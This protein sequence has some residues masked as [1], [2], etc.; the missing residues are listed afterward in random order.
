MTLRFPAAALA[1]LLLLPL[2]A[3]SASAGSARAEAPSAYADERRDELLALAAD[4]AAQR[5]L[6]A[7]WVEQTLLHAQRLPAVLRLM[8]PA[9]AGTAKNWAAYR[10]R[11]VEPL[12]TRAGVAFWREHAHWLREAEARWGVPPEIVVGVIGVET[13]YGRQLGDFRVLDVLT[14]LSLDFPK[15]ARR[16]R[17]AFFRDELATYLLLCRSQDLDPLALR[18]SYAG[19]SGQPQFMP[20]SL[21]RYAVDFDGDG[22][23]DL[24]HSAADTIGSV[25]NYLAEFGWQRGMA[26]HHAVLEPVDARD[27]ATLLAPDIVPSF[28]AAE[29]G[30]LGAVLDPAGQQYAGPLALVELQNGDA[31]PSYVAGTQN[32]YVI[33][34]Y[35]WSS[36]YALAVI[37]LGQAVRAVVDATR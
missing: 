29:F 19:A 3:P 7:A 35:N 12:R 8:Q 30:A 16:D 24:R 32:F 23:V 36:Y 2:A 25:A 28:S 26:T 33:T 22:R 27:R 4:V 11:F 9:P 14:T 37:E 21:L 17:S 6:D 10:S 13:I 31:A 18:G 20:T 15:S 5:G 1:A 34:R